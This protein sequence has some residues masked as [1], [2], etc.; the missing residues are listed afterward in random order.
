[1]KSL[2]EYSK[3]I[4]DLTLKI[5]QDYPELYQY[6]D[7]NPVTIPSSQHPHMDTKAFSDYLQSLREL[8]EEHIKTH[9]KNNQKK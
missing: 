4:Y 8:L 7:E 5:E 9:Q 2:K 1:M 3:A 6:L